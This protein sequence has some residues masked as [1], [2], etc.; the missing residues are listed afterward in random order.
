M[1]FCTRK[2]DPD[3]SPKDRKKLADCWRKIRR[4]KLVRSAS[5]R[6]LAKRE[7]DKAYSENN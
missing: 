5:E 7:F 2:V 3:M 6:H 4:L 1:A